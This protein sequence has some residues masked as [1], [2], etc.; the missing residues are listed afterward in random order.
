MRNSKLFYTVF[1][2][3]ALGCG[4]YFS[5]KPWKLYFQQNEKAQKAISQMKKT[6]KERSELIRKKAY[7]ESPVGKEE[8]AR[9]RGYRKP[10]ELPIETD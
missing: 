2:L 8:L 9:N 5:I 4:I 7:Y 3:L 10:N 1:F 6:E